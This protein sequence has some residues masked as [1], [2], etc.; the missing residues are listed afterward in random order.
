MRNFPVRNTSQPRQPVARRRRR[1]LIVVAA[2]VCSALLAVEND[3]EQVDSG[4]AVAAPPPITFSAKHASPKQQVILH[5]VL[6]QAPGQ[7]LQ[8]GPK[9]QA[10]N[11]AKVSEKA[12]GTGQ[13]SLR[14]AVRPDGVEGW[15]PASPAAQ[16]LK[17]PVG[18]EQD[19]PQLNAPSNTGTTKETSASDDAPAG[20]GANDADDAAAREND[21]PLK[22][23][24]SQK[25][26]DVE[27]PTVDGESS[28]ESSGTLLDE[29]TSRAIAEQSAAEADEKSGAAE[30]AVDQP[31]DQSVVQPV[32]TESRANEPD[33]ER[34]NAEDSVVEAT[35]KPTAPPP[36]TKQL[37]NLR[38]RVRSV[39]K[40]YYR[41]QLNSR[42]NDPW[43]VMHGMLAYGVHSRIRQGGSRGSSV[44][45]VG[46]LC[47]NKPCK[48]LTLM[49]VTPKGELRAKYGVG[50]QG[51]LGQLLAMLAQCR[52]SEEYPIRVGKREFTIKDLIEAEKKTCY[53]KSE[54]T[55]KLIALQYYLDLNDTWVND[56]GVEWDIPRLIREE[57]A[58]PIR[59]AACG[60][61]HRLSSLSLTVKNRQRRGE[62]L[63]GEYARAA[64]FV[65]KYHRYT[66]G[67]QNRDGS[68]STAWFRGRGDDSDI[69]RRIKTT[70]HILEWLCYSLSDEELRDPKTIAAVTYLANLMYSKYDTEWE[71]GPMCHAIHALLV[72]DERVFQP[73]D[74]DHYTAT[75]K[76]KSKMPAAT[77][78]RLEPKTGRR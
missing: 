25:T 60:G 78:K 63:D 21:E 32:E 46:W 23:S 10:A 15:R 33:D 22:W 59:G 45:S 13:G 37:V 76:P 14:F 24:S 57:L 4:W 6:Q 18:M 72:Y 53:P 64:E 54:L 34:Q 35:T 9:T 1:A 17:Q 41:R 40:G 49:Y 3:A 12:I 62:P 66:F 11:S 52:V 61:T 19:A 36:L 71:V 58:Q 70:G 55:F 39:L 67:L 74:G 68:L 77:A 38:S 8:H 47:Y 27:S 50:L 48:N 56:Q 2:L 42:E 31:A 65:Q 16:P 43:E 51:H 44:T 73:F 69:N 75:Y 7:L 5:E 30:Q 20:H 26:N 29:A 28:D